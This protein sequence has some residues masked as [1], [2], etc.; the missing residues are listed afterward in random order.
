MQRDCVATHIG[1]W[2]LK[3]IF[4]H[5]R[6][7][8]RV[9]GASPCFWEGPPGNRA[10]QTKLILGKKLPENPGQTIFSHSKFSL[11]SSPHPSH[12]IRSPFLGAPGG[13]TVG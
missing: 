12:G 11:M 8:P 1:G 6:E 3:S 5:W 9:A 7:V 10:R 13:G 4:S 2:S